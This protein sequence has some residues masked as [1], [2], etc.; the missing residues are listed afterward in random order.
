MSLYHGDKSLDAEIYIDMKTGDVIM[1]YTLN[2][3]SSAYSSNNSAVLQDDFSKLTVITR[4]VEIVKRAPT[5]LLAGVYM[6]ITVPIVTFVL[7]R[8]MVSNPV[9]QL[10]HQRFMKWLFQY[11]LFSE[12]QIV[13]GPYRYNE[14]KFHLPK[15]LWME[16][17]LEGD[18]QKFAS[19]IKLE[20]HFVHM[21]KFG[22]YDQI[23][24][25]GWDLIFT[26]DEPPKE[27]R[28]IIES[29]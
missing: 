28:C 6:G 20:R 16:Y 15:N 19:S 22:V 13:Q 27:G 17:R 25:R 4:F 12:I 29:I 14:L 24:Q 21:K 23:R 8:G 18:F 5:T 11:N 9:Y 3:V 2:Q 10:E 7:S 1:D 26:F